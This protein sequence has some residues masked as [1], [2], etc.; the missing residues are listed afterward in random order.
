MLPNPADA[1]PAP[2]TGE[3]T[4]R[5]RRGCKKKVERGGKMRRNRSVDNV[6]RDALRNTSVGVLLLLLL[7]VLVA[8]AVLVLVVLGVLCVPHP[9]GKNAS[10]FNGN[11]FKACGGIHLG[12]LNLGVALV[13]K[14]FMSTLFSQWR[15][16]QDILISTLEVAGAIPTPQPFP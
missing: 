1:G 13:V 8:L 4:P 9:R 5:E 12:R 16:R 14:R 7:L 11:T 3:V 15:R 2:L 10:M 6:K